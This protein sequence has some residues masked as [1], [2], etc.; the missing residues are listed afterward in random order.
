MRLKAATDYGLR[1]VLYLAMRGTMCSSKDIARSVSIPRDYLIQLAQL[2]RNAGIIEARSG[3]S[4]GYC[5][6]R[7]PEEIS[8][9]QIFNALDDDA[10]DYTRERREERAQAPMAPQV[11][12]A[13]DAATERYD[14]FFAGITLADLLNE[15]EPGDES[16]LA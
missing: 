14:S 10:S 2:L 3:K 16:A 5:L 13:Y 1:A 8:L 6:A 4:G 11:K 7:R 9:L 12:R 15:A